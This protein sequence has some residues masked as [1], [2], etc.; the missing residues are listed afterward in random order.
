MP[1]IEFTTSFVT[2]LIYHAQVAYGKLS[3][4]LARKEDYGICSNSEYNTL[5][6]LYHYIKYLDNVEVVSDNFDE[7]QALYEQIIKLTGLTYKEIGESIPVTLA[8]R[9][10]CGCSGS[11]ASDLTDALVSALMFDVA[12]DSGSLI[13]VE[14]NDQVGFYGIDGIYT[15]T[16]GN[17]VY[18]GY[19]R[20]AATGTYIISGG[21]AVR[22]GT[23]LVYDVSPATYVITGLSYS[24][25]GGQTV[26]QANN[27]PNDRI[28]AIVFDKNGQAGVIQ[29]TASPDRL[30]PYVDPELY[31]TAQ[32]VIIPGTNSSQPTYSEIQV[33]DEN[34]GL[35]TEWTTLDTQFGDADN[36]D[37]P[38]VNT[39][40]IQAINTDPNTLGYFMP[41]YFSTTQHQ[42]QAGVT[43]VSFRL[44][45]E[46]GVQLNGLYIAI[47]KQITYNL[48]DFA[49]SDG[50]NGFST[51]TFDQWMH[52]I[53]PF[54]A[55]TNHHSNDDFSRIYLYLLGNSWSANSYVYID[56]VKIIRDTSV[57]PPPTSSNDIFKFITTGD[58]N[59]ITAD[60]SA[61]ELYIVGDGTYIQTIAADQE[62]IEI[63]YIGPNIERTLSQVGDAS[64]DAAKSLY[65][66]TA[67]T[68]V[69][70]EAPNNNVVLYM[71]PANER[72][73]VGVVPDTTLHV[74]GS[75][76]FE[77]GNEGN[78]L[79]LRSNA[80]GVADWS[81]IDYSEIANT[82]TIPDNYVNDVQL[83][84][85]TLD[86]TATGSAY[87]Q[88][89]D[90][91]SIAGGITWEEVTSNTSMVV[92]RGYVT[93][94]GGVLTHTLPATAAVGSI[95]EVAG[96]AGGWIIAQQAG[97]K[98]IFGQEET[99][100]GTG[101][102][103]ASNQ[104]N[105]SIR[106]V[107]ITADTEWLVLSSVGNLTIS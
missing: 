32:F 93:N 44:Y 30:Y 36:T 65:T 42:P 15:Y 80:N 63:E 105:D 59:T 3:S 76:K 26:H 73:G 18:I 106:M 86:F 43:H 27:D 103:I 16:Q 13:T 56:D 58:N 7:I 94:G 2:K 98:I 5:E 39:K 6:Y 78:G 50:S 72:V 45:V 11:I 66:M 28:D 53:L 75:I 102:S 82:P 70:F 79:Y 97:Q 54:N 88:S 52:I 31:V 12:A 21:E 47:G 34:I 69:I 68:P 74:L 29:G 89:V 60:G 38:F 4:K 51:S 92:N 95:I 23:P 96:K 35:P 24:Y 104:A 9:N 40:A 107:C 8:E 77:T 87:S 99:T 91:S 19:T 83:I 85:N 64:T 41:A 62:T 20:Q 90:L 48:L 46:S 81:Q 10:G 25:S 57:S 33:Y 55:A 49:V 1:T 14:S 100:T 37:N 71:D 17:D 67:G 61:D 84:G 22:S 101:G